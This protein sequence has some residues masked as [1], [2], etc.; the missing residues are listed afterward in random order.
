MT[1]T[2]EPIADQLKRRLR[3][4]GA[5]RFESISAHTGVA[6]SFIR[7]FVYGSRENPR[8]QTI[9]PLLDYFA[10]VDRGEIDLGR[11]AKEAAH[12]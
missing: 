11:E 4:A 7:K 12:G 1:N 10:A 6:L 8:V 9:Q 5:S 3:E 2:I